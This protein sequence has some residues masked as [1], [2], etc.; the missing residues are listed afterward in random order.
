MPPG[1]L[2]LDVVLTKR[3][4]LTIDPEES[5]QEHEARLK[6]E[7][8]EHTFEMVKGYVLF[9]VIVLSIT[10]VGGLFAYE[11]VFDGSASSDTKRVALTALS[12]L[13]AGGLSFVLGQATA[14]KSK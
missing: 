13:F 12:S 7:G 3:A 8:R 1:E 4:T 9:V 6:K 10:C 11:A 5:P 2:N 14:K